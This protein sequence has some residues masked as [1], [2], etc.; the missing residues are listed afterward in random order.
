[1]IAGGWFGEIE[2]FENI[3]RHFSVRTA[4]ASDFYVLDRGTVA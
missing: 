2:I 4:E 1:M 3:L